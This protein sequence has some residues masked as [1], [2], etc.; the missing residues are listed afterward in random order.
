MKSTRKLFNKTPHLF[1]VAEEKNFYI[2]AKGT[3][4]FCKLLGKGIPSKN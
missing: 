4:L 3:K 2:D 1:S